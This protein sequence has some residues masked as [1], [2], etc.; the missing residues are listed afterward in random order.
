MIVKTLPIQQFISHILRKSREQGRR[1]EY[2][3]HREEG[4]NGLGRP[5]QELAS[6]EL[7]ISGSSLTSLAPLRDSNSSCSLEEETA[8]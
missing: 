3:S 5:E 8:N 7:A 6:T 2:A 1:G 4:R